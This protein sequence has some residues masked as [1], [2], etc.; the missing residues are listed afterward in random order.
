MFRRIFFGQSVG[1]FHWRV[2]RYILLKEF[3][4][5]KSFLGRFLILIV[6]FDGAPAKLDTGN[7]VM[8][9]K[10]GNLFGTIRVL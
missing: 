1:L 4:L 2:Y 8:C 6:K 9:S 10:R 3:S 5:R 7:S